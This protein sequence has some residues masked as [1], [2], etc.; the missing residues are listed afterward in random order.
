MEPSV[1]YLTDK[2]SICLQ[3]PR[4]APQSWGHMTVGHQ[5][6]VGSP[7]LPEEPAHLMFTSTGVR[8]CLQLI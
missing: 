5:L 8:S 7:V 3:W 1:I 2:I 6:I 4:G